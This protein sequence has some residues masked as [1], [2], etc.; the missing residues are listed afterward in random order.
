M[1]ANILRVLLVEDSPSDQFLIR[2]H[3]YDPDINFEVTRAKRLSSAVRKLSTDRFDCV[4]LD[5]HLPDGEGVEVIRAVTQAAHDAAVV[6]MTGES[7]NP[8]S[9]IAIRHGAQDFLV[10]DDV[11]LQ[12]LTRVVRF[13]VQRKRIE[14]QIENSERRLALVAR[15]SHDAIWD[16][17]VPRDS[18]Y[19]SQSWFR[20][21]GLTPAPFLAPLD[22]WIERVHP[23]D[24][25]GFRHRLEGGEADE[26][27]LCT[28][29]YRL[30]DSQNAYRPMYA[31]WVIV[32]THGLVTR[33][34][35]IQIDVERTWKP[36]R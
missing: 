9:L 19:R 5:L 6:V 7:N 18:L 1:E 22:D 10:K 8:L 32:K 21:L 4:I 15:A 11:A 24:R 3:L 12:T 2:E 33:C 13:A 28:A 20:M 26:Q 35:G 25:D 27:G 31:R 29:H 14:Q 30:R 23:E 34:V 17:D 16:W 36:N